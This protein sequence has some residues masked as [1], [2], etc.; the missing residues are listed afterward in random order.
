MKGKLI[1]IEGTD[2]SGKATQTALLCEKLAKEGVELR[3]LS[4]PRYG[5]PSAK[6]VEMYLH[7]E[8]GE[9]PNAISPYETS[10]F[11]AID[12]YISYHDDWGKFYESGGIIVTDRYTTANAVHQSAKMDKGERD[13]FFG[14]LHD[15]EHVKMGIPAP[16]L[17]LYLDM[18]L[19][20]TVKLMRAREEKTNTKADIH[21][22]DVN[23]LVKSKEG[24][25]D[26]AKFY[27]WKI[28]SC[29]ENGEP[30]S[31]DAIHEDIYAEVSIL[32]NKE[33]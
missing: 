15:L 20:V 11:Y 16:D 24:A 22:K 18:P 9:D 8:F 3:K 29:A 2:G 28:I 4:F 10:K 25:L 13:Q 21:E 33:S 1:V 31:L 27:G 5:N 23:H 26:A 12:R 7:G 30:R 32:L 17:V 14:W 6:L 19:D